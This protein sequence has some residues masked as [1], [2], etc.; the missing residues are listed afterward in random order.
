MKP[1]LVARP[2][3]AAVGL[4]WFITMAL[5]AQAIQCSLANVAGS[6][7]YTTSGFVPIAPRTFFPAAAAGRIT[8]YGDGHV[9]GIHTRGAAGRFPGAEVFGTVRGETHFTGRF[10]SLGGSVN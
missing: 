5:P 2:T 4:A 9:H 7:G 10:P 8:F 3:L 6:Y 1:T